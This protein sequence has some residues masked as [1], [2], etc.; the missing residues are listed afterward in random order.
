MIDIIIFP[1][2]IWHMF[3]YDGAVLNNNLNLNLNYVIECGGDNRVNFSR[4]GRNRSDDVND[5]FL[6]ASGGSSS[7]FRRAVIY[8]AAVIE[9]ITII[10]QDFETTNSCIFY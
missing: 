4:E 8:S 1:V 3:W 5:R 6:S 9:E 7:C 2:F 10:I